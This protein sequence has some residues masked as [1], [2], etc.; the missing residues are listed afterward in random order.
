MG[1]V[2]LSSA[3]QWEGAYATKRMYVVIKKDIVTFESR[4]SSRRGRERIIEI[5]NK[6]NAY[7]LKL[8]SGKQV[9]V[10]KKRSA[11]K[12]GFVGNNGIMRDF[13]R[14]Y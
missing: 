9:W 1:F 8:E 2:G 6:E 10:C 14:L 12:D 3:E 5:N 11:G 7:V 4:T 13:V